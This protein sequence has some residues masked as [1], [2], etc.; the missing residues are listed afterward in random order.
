MRRTD[1][2]DRRVARGFA[3][4]LVPLLAAGCVAMPSDGSPERVR[5]PDPDASEN[6]QVRVYAMPPHPGDDPKALLSAFLDAA[7]ADD[8][9]YSTALEYL[10]P[11][12]VK[13]W[14]PEER[15]VV[16]DTLPRP[17]TVAGNSNMAE[18]SGTVEVEIRGTK[19]AELD[20]GRT[21]TASQVTSYTS[22]FRL[23]RQAEGPN[24]GEW[25]IDDLPAGLITDQARFKNSYRS[26]HRYFPTLAD[27]SVDP[28]D[29]ANRPVLVPD[30]IYLRTRLDPLT[31]AA[32]ALLAGPS[33]WLEPGV[34][35]AFDRSME[36]DGPVTVT[37]GQAGTVRVKGLDFNVQDSRCQEMV[38]QLYYT[39]AEVQGKQRLRSLTL[40]GDRGGCSTSGGSDVFLAPGQLAGGEAGTR[41]YYL[42]AK[43]SKSGPL[44]VASGLGSKGTSVPGELGIKERALR[45]DAFAVRRDTAEAAVIT[46]DSRDLFL[47]PLTEEGVRGPTVHQ[48]AGGRLVSPS[49]DGRN[50][51]WLVE[52]P[53]QGAPRVLMVRDRK[54]VQ[55]RLG[56]LGGGQVQQLKVSSDGSRI[57]LVVQQDGRRKLR[58]GIVRHGGT[59]QAP[60]V[61]VVGLTDREVAP[62]LSDVVSVAW[63]DTDQLLVLGKELDKLQQLHYFGTDGSVSADV[64]L[65]GG[66]SMLAVSATEARG[67]GKVPPAV[68]ATS[69]DQ[70]YRLS[71]S[72]WVELAPGL[73][74][75]QFSY[76]G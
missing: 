14:K 24:K 25:R 58:L 8:Q 68:L 3:A 31:A 71:G 49:W 61:E 37:E 63:A 40:N 21:Y 35:T 19:T 67:D 1:R 70:I 65:Q 69:R 74:D 16:L 42:D 27:P 73:K 38:T 5:E 13:R 43:D 34:R 17:A 62:A 30:P 50:N 7:N 72:Q 54:L 56:E 18:E 45:P 4:L 6:L 12:A 36:L 39:L 55:V 59:R 75:S 57:A 29:P 22:T 33:R 48:S 53:P 28:A 51:L 23:V 10:T 52:V 15:V 2:A 46:S 26:V 41:Q 9:N 76:P 47:V 60:E 32:K 64:P 20:R 11:A 66:D 44:M